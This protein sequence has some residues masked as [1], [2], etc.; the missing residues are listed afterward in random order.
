MNL[1][2]FQYALQVNHRG[3]FMQTPEGWIRHKTIKTR[4]S[5]KPCCPFGVIV[6]SRNYAAA[7]LPLHRGGHNM[8]NKTLRWITRAAD[9]PADELNEYEQ[10]LRRWMQ[11]VLVG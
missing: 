5:N 7:L 3:E 9:R 8:D 2:E 10:H 1:F 6:P 4:A 11:E